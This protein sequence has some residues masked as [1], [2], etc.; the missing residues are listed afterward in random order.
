M[1]VCNITKNEIS[2]IRFFFFKLRYFRIAPR[3]L[4][5]YQQ[6]SEKIQ[7]TPNVIKNYKNDIKKWLGCMYVKMKPLTRL[8][9]ITFRIS[10][11]MKIHKIINFFQFDEKI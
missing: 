1:C 7:N 9:S 6:K 2:I 5:F 11:K 10:D 3:T 8:Y 4:C